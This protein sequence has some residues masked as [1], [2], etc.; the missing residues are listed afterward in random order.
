LGSALQSIRTGCVGKGRYDDLL[1]NVD[2]ALGCKIT[3]D[4][5]VAGG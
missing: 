4:E 1:S 2:I 3:E 5:W